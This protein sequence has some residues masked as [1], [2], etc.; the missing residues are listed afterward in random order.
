M[1]QSSEIEN[2]RMNVGMEI[3][4]NE[5]LMEDETII[6]TLMENLSL[7]TQVSSVNQT[8]DKRMKQNLQQFACTKIIMETSWEKCN[9][10]GFLR[11][12]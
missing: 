8:N 2:L 5:M 12:K 6:K 11:G 1:E 9:L 7:Q 4:E 3:F 10:L